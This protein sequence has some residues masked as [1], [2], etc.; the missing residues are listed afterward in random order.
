MKKI[1]KIAALLA[2]VTCLSCAAPM[3]ACVYKDE[4]DEHE[5]TVLTVKEE[6]VKDYNTMPVFRALARETGKDVYWTYN[7]SMQYSNNSNP[8]GI[9]GIDAIYHAGFSNLQ[10]YNYGKRGKIVAIDQYIDKYMPNFKAILEKRPDIKEAISTSFP[11]SNEKH[12]YSLPRIEEMGLKS[13]P[14][15][16]FINKEWIKELIA[17]GDS[18]VAGLEESDLTDG[19]KLTRGQYKN[20][21]LAFKKKHSGCVPLAFV[22]DNWQGNESDFIASFGVPEN[23]EHKTIVDDKVIFTVED[24]NWYRAVKTMQEWYSAEL[25]S[26]SAFTQSQDEFLARGQDGRYASFYWWE[27]DTVVSKDRRDDYI[28]LQPL[29]DDETGKQYVGLSN[30]LEIEKSECVIL[31]TCKDKAGLL[32]Y[33]DKFFEPEYSAQLNYGSI[34]SGAFQKQK[35][36]GKLIPNDDHGKQSADDFRM[37][38]APYGVVYLTQEV[39]DKDVEMESR[40]K[41]RLE[42]LETYVKPYNE[43]ADYKSLSAQYSGEELASKL[44]GKTQIKSIPNL[45]Y[46]KE[47]LDALNRYETM[48]GNN[49]NS[50][51][52][53]RI[54]SG[55]AISESDWQN[56]LINANKTAMENVIRVNQVAYDRYV[57]AIAA[58]G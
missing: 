28:V 45:D 44:Q 49:I 21:L 27:K 32:S 25:I 20:I 16:L 36:D 2:A 57:K 31:S 55:K 17:A 26:S 40:A 39:W 54:I 5:F 35:V 15:L 47:E 51:M 13:Y 34:D 6:T 24:K 52:V 23:M 4:D 7:T 42:R 50:W 10:L 12:I 53:N 8:V 37:K 56:N 18:S 33:F 30:E 19:L 3:T 14:N 46:T 29:V 41:L 43:Y 22:H 38:N 11:E 58:N 48:L 9:K 1:K